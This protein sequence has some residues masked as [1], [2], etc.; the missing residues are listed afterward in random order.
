MEIRMTVIGISATT[1]T[2]RDA[3]R[4]RVNAAYIHA[5]ERSGAVPVV[6][7]PI[8]SSERAGE[9]LDRVDGLI[10]TGG[11]DIDPARYDAAAHAE[12]GSPNAARD[13]TELALTHA[14]RERGLPTLAICR[15]IQLLNVALGGTLVQDIPSERPSAVDH[16]PRGARDVR[17]HA[18]VVEPGSAL[19]AALGVDGLRANS[20]HHQ[21]VDRVAPGLGVTAR[22]PDGIVEGVE[23]IGDGAWW[24]L[25][26]QW[27]PE[28]LVDGTEGWDRNLFAALAHQAQ[29][30]G[31][32]VV[33][34]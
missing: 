23:W 16:D 13:A 29:N 17:A 3:L 28:E 34:R 5:V 26:V 20:F 15:G 7:P 11:E 31:R 2:I 18:I 8:Q 10:L 30:Y 9:M 22:A 32:T 6:L 21:A 4:T 25:G 14:A 1:E 12:T 27:H 24:A 19:A 33:G